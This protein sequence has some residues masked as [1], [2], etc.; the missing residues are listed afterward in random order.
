MDRPPIKDGA[1]LFSHG[2]IA[3]IGP[4][5][6]LLKSHPSATL[7]DLGQS[8]LLPG[9]VNAHCHLELSNHPLGGPPASFVDWL[10][11]LMGRPADVSA[12][13]ELGVNQ[14]LRFGVTTLGD[15]TRQ[16]AITRPLLTHGPL[17]I[18]SYGE[19]QAMAKR[20]TLL[21]ERFAIAADVS[22]ESEYLRVGITPHAPYS[23]EPDGYRRCLDFAIQNHRPIATHLAETPD[24][25]AF[26]AN[27]TG[28][29]R[30]LWGFLNAWDEVVPRF[31]GGPIRYAQS[32]GLL[33]Y[34]TLLAHVNYCDRAE[35]DILAAGRAS[36]V[37]CPRTHE[38]FAHPPHRFREM[39]ARGINVAVGTDSCASSPDLNLLDDLRLLRRIAQE[40]PAT[41]LLA[42]A[43]IRAARAIGMDSQ[44]GSLTPG[45][46]ADAVAFPARDLDDL[47]NH[48]LLPSAVWI[49]GRLI[50][51]P[52]H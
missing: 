51:T 27:H 42:M 34:P 41:D 25:A 50:S 23:I 29:F 35:L 1:V 19:V 26:L 15:I 36:V 30:K 16:C 18:V 24:E 2:K 10:T 49:G 20:R 4:A 11:D 5:R 31:A 22:H 9:L 3:D 52:A 48:P 39:L 28:P 6:E 44:V 7:H 46:A 13:I 37:Y 43:T 21:N 40:M 12:A 45:K 14:S 33:D 17:R 38:Y 32:L 8:V 47:L